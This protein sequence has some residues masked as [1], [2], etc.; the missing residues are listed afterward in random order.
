MFLTLV[1]THTSVS[2]SLISVYPDNKQGTQSNIS[3]LRGET[4]GKMLTLRDGSLVINGKKTGSV[5]SLNFPNQSG[6]I[7]TITFNPGTETEF[8]ELVA[9]LRDT[10]L[11]Q[12]AINKEIGRK[13]ENERQQ[14]AKLANALYSDVTAIRNTGIKPDLES[15]RSSIKDA[16][17]AIKD[18]EVHLAELKH[19]ASVRPMTCYQA[20]KTV[21]YVFEQTMR[22]DFSRTLGYAANNFKI[23]FQRLEERLGRVSGIETKINQEANDLKQAINMAKFAVPKLMILPGEEQAPLKQYQELATSARKEM[24]NLQ[25]KFD[26]AISRAQELMKEGQQVMTAA[27]DLVRCK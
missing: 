9:K 11:S 25:Q 24:T 12:I 15:M 16:Y 7:S 27:Q 18:I 3:S 14:L 26:Y 22:Y 20:N 5:I 13:A 21:K 19:E 8:N 4:D 2:G 10:R 23:D 17:S 6:L 1:Q